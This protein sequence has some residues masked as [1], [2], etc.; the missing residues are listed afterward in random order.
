MFARVVGSFL[1]PLLSLSI[2]AAETP[3]EA[4]VGTLEQFLSAFNARDAAAW[5]DAMHFPYTTF[6]D[7]QVVTYANRESVV[8][9]VD[10]D[11]FA[12]T[13]GWR[14]SR[15]ESHRVIQSS[16]VKVH[17]AVRI[18]RY[19]ASDQAF[20][21]FDGVFVIE[22]IEGRWAVRAYSRLPSEL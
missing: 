19:N 3:D 7:G 21:V 11:T 16:D 17:V 10:F 4:A 8:E 14:R 15:L 5:A 12:E 1:I 20:A 18:A 9:G 22:K 2:Q 13:T 6:S